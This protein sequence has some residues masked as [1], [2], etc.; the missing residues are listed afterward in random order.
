MNEDLKKEMHHV[1]DGVAELHNYM[2]ELSQRERYFVSVI[3]LIILMDV[4][5]LGARQGR[6]DMKIAIANTLKHTHE[7]LKRIDAGE[8][9]DII[10]HVLKMMASLGATLDSINGEEDSDD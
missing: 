3:S 2:D 6:D 9:F 5:R 8:E 7:M 10:A 4:R 1:C